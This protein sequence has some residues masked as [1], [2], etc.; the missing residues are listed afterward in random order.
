MKL[1]VWYL[2]DGLKVCMPLDIKSSEFFIFF[3]NERILV[4]RHAWTSNELGQF[5]VNGFIASSANGKNNHMD[6]ECNRWAETILFYT[7]FICCIKL[8]L[9]C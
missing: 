7:L 5:A 2:F 1:K 4:Q 6:K 3:L 8:Q 9:V